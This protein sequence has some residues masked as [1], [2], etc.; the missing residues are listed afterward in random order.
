VLT[1]FRL[2]ED[3]AAGDY[4]CMDVADDGSGIAPDALDRIFD[5]F[6]STKFVGRGLGLAAVLGIVK[7]H[8]GLLKVRSGPDGTC[9]TVAF[10]AA[11]VLAARKPPA[12]AGKAVLLLTLD[13]AVAELAPRALTSVGFAVTTETDGA[14]AVARVGQA[15]RRFTAAI[16]DGVLPG[17]AGLELVAGLRAQARGLPI[18]VLGN[19]EAAGPGIVSLPGVTHLPKPFAAA[20][21]VRALTSIEQARNPR[22]RVM[23]VDNT[24]FRAALIRMLDPTRVEIVGEPCDAA[25]AILQAN[26]L[27]PD[28]ILMDVAA[29]SV[30]GIDAADEIKRSLPD[31]RIIL[32]SAERTARDG[33]S[34]A[35]AGGDANLS[36]HD[37]TNIREAVQGY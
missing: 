11:E 16:I 12:G 31:T 35:K 14:A 27:R 17:L 7:A 26:D 20:E 22:V 9:F 5:P 8:E 32:I 29:S 10:P 18:V 30:D 23:I 36:K 21:L 4:I 19:H 28:V 3:A 24:S 15:P 13:S 34:G 6:F 2:S 37:L 33:G 1:T 25:E